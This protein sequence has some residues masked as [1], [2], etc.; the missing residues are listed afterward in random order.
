MLISGMNGNKTMIMLLGVALIIGGSLYLLPTLARPIWSKSA[1][2]QNATVPVYNCPYGYNG[3]WVQG[4]DGEY[5]PPCY[6]PEAGEFNPLYNQTQN[7]YGQ[8]CGYGAG[9]NQKGNAWRNQQSQ[10]TGWLGNMMR[11]VN[12]G[13]GNGF[14]RGGCGRTG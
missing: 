7:R 11:G 10:S 12:A 8:M 5:Y 3:T 1:N 13:G 2:D 4:E 14:R 6:D 9:L